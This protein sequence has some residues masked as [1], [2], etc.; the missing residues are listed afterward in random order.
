MGEDSRM[1]VNL[2]KLRRWYI[3]RKLTLSRGYITIQTFFIGVIFS[4]SV[5]TW[6][7]QYFKTNW[8]FILLVIIS[9]LILYT[10]GYLDIKFRVLHEENKI[11]S[12]W[13]PF[14]VEMDKKITKK[15]G[16]KSEEV[17]YHYNQRHRK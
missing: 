3:I 12:E 10:V 16:E 6:L 1:K 2:V 4:S 15:I 5:K 8:S 7:P 13:N 11:G 17:K 14:M 9:M